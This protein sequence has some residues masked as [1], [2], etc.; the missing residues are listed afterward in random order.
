MFLDK[1][2]LLTPNVHI[3]S[4]F[5]TF[6]ETGKVI[7]VPSSFIHTLNKNEIE[8]T[9]R[10]YYQEIKDRKNVILLGDRIDDL[11]MVEGLEHDV[12]LKIGFYNCDSQTLEEYKKHFDLIITNDGTMEEVNKLL[13]SIL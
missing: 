10:P 5:C 6:D 2:D 11:G 12:V 7:E 4:N 1:H 13:K 3:V 9:N 8:I